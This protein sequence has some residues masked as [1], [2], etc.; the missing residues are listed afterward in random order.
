[1][2]PT[3]FELAALHE[4]ENC[5]GR[6]LLSTIG[7]SGRPT[8]E[9]DAAFSENVIPEVITGGDL[10]FH[11]AKGEGVKG[12]RHPDAKMVRTR[13][14]KYIYYGSGA[15]ELYDLQN[16]PQ[17]RRDLASD[18]GHKAIVDDLQRRLLNWLITADEVDQIAPRWLIPK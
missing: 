18:P 5:Q 11:F 8:P 10:D 15:A 12:V 7:K 6:S 16:D 2:L 1:M 9:R 3:L 14:W 13:R 4:P 17:E